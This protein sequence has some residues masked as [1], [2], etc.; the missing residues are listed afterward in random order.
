MISFSFGYLISGGREEGSSDPP[1]PLLDL[2]LLSQVNVAGHHQ[3]C[4]M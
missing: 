2:P 4:V 3:E 1:E